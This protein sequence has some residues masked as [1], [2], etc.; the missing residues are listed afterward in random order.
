LVGG[1]DGVPGEN[2]R[3]VALI[4]IVSGFSGF[5]RKYN[6]IYNQV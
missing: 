1:G 6:Y 2:H 4:D 5:C 3:P